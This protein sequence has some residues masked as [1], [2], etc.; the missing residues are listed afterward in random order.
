MANPPF[1]DTPSSCSPNRNVPRCPQQT[2][3]ER[4]AR[5]ASALCGLARYVAPH[6][7]FLG[8]RRESHRVKLELIESPVELGGKNSSADLPKLWLLSRLMMFTPP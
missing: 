4:R 7:I 2:L 1:L 3:H 6:L 8:T 5:S